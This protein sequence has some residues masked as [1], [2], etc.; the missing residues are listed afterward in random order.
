MIKKVTYEN[1]NM[2]NKISI[3]SLLNETQKKINQ[4]NNKRQ[5]AAIIIKLTKKE[6][7]VLYNQDILRL[8][9]LGLLVPYA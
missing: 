8:L 3:Y 7:Q 1:K 9:L 2:L 5:K 6:S 4:T